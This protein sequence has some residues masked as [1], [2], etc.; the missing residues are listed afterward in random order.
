MDKPLLLQRAASIRARAEAAHLEIVI[1]RGLI[2]QLEKDGRDAT[3][4]ELQLVTW[5][6]T[7]Q[8]LLRE[9]D[10]VLDRLDRLATD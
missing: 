6:M 1:S 4:A 5:K 3:D 2:A 9:L 7:E 10:W 8:K